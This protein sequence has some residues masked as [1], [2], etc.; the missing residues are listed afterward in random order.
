[1]S[2][3][4]EFD[5]LPLAAVAPSGE[6]CEKW[7]AA[8]DT[9][10][11]VAGSPGQWGYNTKLGI[12]TEC[13]GSIHQVLFALKTSLACEAGE[14]QAKRLRIAGAYWEWLR[15]YGR[16]TSFSAF[17]NEFGYQAEDCKRVYES[18]VVPCI[19]TFERLMKEVQ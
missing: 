11:R 18:V 6:E 12:L 16:L 8:L 17:V 10:L 15:R 3:G 13:L 2:T 1:M 7:I 19:E 4:R 14:I 9:L 5:N